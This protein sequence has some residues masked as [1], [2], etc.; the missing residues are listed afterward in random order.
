MNLSPANTIRMFLSAAAASCLPSFVNSTTF[1]VPCSLARSPSTPPPS[2]HPAQVRVATTARY[3]CR[4]I[5]HLLSLR[6][7]PYASRP[8]AVS[9]AARLGSLQSEYDA[10]A[11]GDHTPVEYVVNLHLRGAESGGRGSCRAAWRARL[12]PSRLEGEAPAEP[13]MRA[14]RQEPRPPDPS[15][16]H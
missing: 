6:A 8:S 4:F 14:A 5:V 16:E 2:P 7:E 12:L 11:S 13:G 1:Q 10:E 9:T 3:R 15:T